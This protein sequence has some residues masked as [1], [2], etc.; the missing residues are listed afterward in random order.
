MGLIIRSIL[1]KVAQGAMDAGTAFLQYVEG[2]TTRGQL[3]TMA[4][5]YYMS[6]CTVASWNVASDTLS[7]TPT[8]MER[9]IFDRAID[10]MNDAIE[11]S[12]GHQTFV[13]TQIHTEKQP[14]YKHPHDNQ[15]M[16]N[17]YKRVQTKNNNSNNA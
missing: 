6:G 2:L 11:L 13:S 5:I 7:H 12:L 4:D 8:R 10:E 1:A 14:H 9:E 16:Q 17:N 15:K 3:E